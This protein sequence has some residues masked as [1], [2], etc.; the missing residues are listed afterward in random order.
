M[1][2]PKPLFKG[3]IVD[4]PNRFTVR[5]KIGSA[6]KRIYLPNP[7]RLSTLIAPGRDILCERVMGKSRKTD[8]NAFAIKVGRSYATVN[9]SFANEIFS[10]AIERRA[11]RD[12]K[13]YSVEARERRIPAYGRIDF[14]LRDPKGK[15]TYVEVK[16]CTHVEEGIAK[17]PDRPTERGRRHLKVLT[18]LASRGFACSLIFI[19]Q[20]ADAKVFKAFRE[21]DPEFAGLLEGAARA[22]VK[23]KAMATGFKPPNLIFVTDPDLPVKLE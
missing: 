2:Y 1:E 8:F 14:V 12:F 9:S 15:L 10:T 5:V 13:G 7:G 17:F 18:D 22:G 3:E 6:V 11:L 4:R 16:S 21:V 23:I 20:R 19:V